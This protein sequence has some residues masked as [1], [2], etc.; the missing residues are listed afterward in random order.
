MSAITRTSRA[1]DAQP[2]REDLGRDA[3][4]RDALARAT[5]TQPHPSWRFQDHFELWA[6]WLERDSAGQ[7]TPVQNVL[8]RTFRT[9]EDTLRHAERFL[10]RGEFPLDRA[11]LTPVALL[12]NRRDALLSAFRGAEGDGVTLIRDLIF[13]VGEYGLSVKVTRERQA[14][15]VR[16]PFASAANPLRSLTGQP[17]RLTVLIEHP[18]DVLSRVDGPLD[19]GERAARVS[20]DTQ[21]FAPGAAVTGVPYRSATVTVPRGLLKKPLLYRYERLDPPAAEPSV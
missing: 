5:P 12:R 15:E 7:W 9:R 2:V 3:A 20:E 13:P 8:H 6:D 4:T 10:S 21:L 11:S 17:V 14:Q 16:A 19:V 1:H 18:Y